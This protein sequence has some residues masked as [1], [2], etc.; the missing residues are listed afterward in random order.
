[1]IEEEIIWKKVYEADLPAIIEEVRDFVESPSV[2]ILSGE[3]GAGKTTFSKVFI[4]K[5]STSSPTYSVIHEIGNI[6]HADLYRL[7]TDEDIIHLEIPLYMEEKDFFLVEWGKKYL[8]TLK[9]LIPEQF[10]YYELCISSNTEASSDSTGP[11]RNYLLSRI[12]E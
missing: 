10:S 8:S 9:K 3:L 11:S 1:M 12:G 5:G 4:D 7:E 2:I 6:A